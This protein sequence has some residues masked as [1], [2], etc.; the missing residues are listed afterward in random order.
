MPEGLL[1]LFPLEVVLLPRAPL[2]LHIFEERYKEMIGLCLDESREFGVVLARGNGVL[3]AGCTA[4]ID[5]V[6]ERYDDGR[7]DILCYGVS[8]F[9]IISIETDRSY[10]QADVRYFEDDDRRP[11]RQAAIREADERRREFAR[12]VNEEPSSVDLEDPQLSFL[13]AQI[14]PDLNF[15][16]MLLQLRSEADRMDRVAEH[17]ASLI[18]RQKTREVMGKVAR[19]NGHGKHLPEIGE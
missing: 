15:R 5:R 2:P 18:E 9:E 17:L 16:Q 19:A 1:P 13:L 10:F 3:R 4:S 8:R 6:V 7:L 12:L 14:S 11:A